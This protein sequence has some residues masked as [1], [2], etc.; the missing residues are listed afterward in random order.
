MFL[1]R[2]P[3]LL[4]ILRP[5]DI[6]VTRREL[7]SES[8]S[9]L[10]GKK[11]VNPSHSKVSPETLKVPRQD[12]QCE[13]R[14]SEH[15]NIFDGFKD[16]KRACIRNRIVSKDAR[17]YHNIILFDAMFLRCSQGH[18]RFSFLKQ[19]RIPFPLVHRSERRNE[20]NHV[21]Q[22]NL[23]M[24]FH[25]AKWNKSNSTCAMHLLHLCY[26]RCSKLFRRTRIS[27]L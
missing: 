18:Q 13:S 12:I 17:R 21:T 27:Y 7:V 26:A 16:T 25:R 6:A 10:S 15:Q 24:T 14:G 23:Q 2:R 9:L 1:E 8:A 3:F 20:S 22:D 11:K 4:D 19:N 5:V